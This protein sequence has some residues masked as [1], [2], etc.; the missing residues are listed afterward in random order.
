MTP[1]LSQLRTV[2]PPP[3]LPPL[4]P[5]PILPRLYLAPPSFTPQPTHLEANLN[6]NE[7]DANLLEQEQIPLSQPLRKNLN[8]AASVIQLRIQLSNA[9]INVQPVADNVIIPF[10]SNP[11]PRVPE[12]VR[13]RVSQFG[14]EVQGARNPSSSAVLSK[15]KEHVKDK[16]E[17][18]ERSVGMV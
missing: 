2:F 14:V 9:H 13:Q 3:P 10:E 1:P 12:Y 16:L 11:V 17:P 18:R 4:F 8:N 5:H 15:M 6:C 7:D